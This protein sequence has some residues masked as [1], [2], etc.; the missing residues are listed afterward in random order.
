M[1]SK[2]SLILALIIIIPLVSAAQ[3]KQAGLTVTSNPQGA[4]VTLKGNLTIIGVTPVQFLQPLDGKYNIQVKK[5][6]FETYKSTLYLQRDK[7]SSLSVNLKAKTRFKG[8]ARSLFIPGWGQYYADRKFKGGIFTVLAIGAI[9]SF[10]IADA[11]YNDKVDRY[12]DME[13]EYNNLTSYGEKEALYSTLAEAR[14][15]AYDAESLRR[16]TIGAAIAVWSL[17]LLD[18]LFLFPENEG[19]LS[20]D[21]ITVKPDLK[22]GGAQVILSHRF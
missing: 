14:K 18:I 4:E 11:D 6:G 15:D 12:E 7:I 5:Y 20:V 16:I 8:F 9:G 19:L 17:N 22:Q 21:N 10:L 3:D 13:V 2:G 1:S